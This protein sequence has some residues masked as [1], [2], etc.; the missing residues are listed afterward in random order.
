[1]KNEKEDTIDFELPADQISRRVKHNFSQANDPAG[2][3]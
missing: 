3:N 1:M 2:I